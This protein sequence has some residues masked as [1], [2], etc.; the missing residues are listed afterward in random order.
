MAMTRPSAPF[1]RLQRFLVHADTSALAGPDAPALSALAIEQGLA[2]LVRERIV[3]A[4]LPWP[5]E[6]LAALR[7]AHHAALARGERQLE[8]ARRALRRLAA[9]GLRALPLK[10]AALVES[11]YDSV[12]E[13][14]MADVDILALDDAPAALRVLRETGFR[15][16]QASDHAVALE[17]P[18]T[19]AVVELHT[20]VTSCGGLFPLDRGALWDSRE[21]G[22]GTVGPRPSPEHQL[23]LLSLH[24]A[25]QHGLVLRLVQF[26]DFRRLFERAR[27]DPRR[28]LELAREAR[29]GA[30]VALA[31]EAA[32]AVV[33]C[34]APVALR[35]AVGALLPRSLRTWLER[36]RAQPHLFVTPAEPD[37]LWLR[38]SLA[39]GRRRTLLREALLAGAPA[40]ERGRLRHAAARA[41]SLAWRWSVASPR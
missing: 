12:A 15:A 21:S 6:P 7:Q 33:G 40:L 24:A 14:P 20:S 9:S 17:D 30:A 5:R 34:P 10:G 13:R 2:G 28:A 22:A 29:A 19:R 36:R 41:A 23:L 38:W 37:L 18:E 1:E 39:Q 27:P 16:A 32:A 35:E 11:L 25:F 31:L 3:E 8:T 4:G 26:L